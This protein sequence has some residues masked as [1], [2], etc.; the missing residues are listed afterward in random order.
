MI[1]EKIY[2][3]TDEEGN[4]KQISPFPPNKHLE[5]IVLID[6]PISTGTFQRHPS[7]KLSAKMKI[8]GDIFSSEPEW[9]VPHDSH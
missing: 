8:K 2:V 5:L 3:D 9:N 1:A 7:Q 6:E 4:I